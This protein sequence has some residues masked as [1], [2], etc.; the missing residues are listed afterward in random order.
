MILVACFTPLQVLIAKEVLRREAVNFSDVFFVYF[1]TVTNEKHQRYYSL[2][3][4]MVGKSLYINVPYSAKLLIIIKRKIA[5]YIYSTIYVASID[6][7][8]THYLLSFCDYEE[9][10]T[11]DDGVGNIIKSGTYFLKAQRTSLKK[12]LFTIVHT[13]LGRRYYLDEV[14]S[15]SLRH[16]TIYDKFDNCFNNPKYIALFEKGKT[17]NSTQKSVKNIILGTMFNEITSHD[18]HFI[19]QRLLDFMESLVPS[20][21]YIPHPRAKDICFKDYQIN[22]SD[23]AEDYVINL[24]N[25]GYEVNLYGFASSSQF[26]LLSSHN[27][28]IY[29]FD[30]EDFKPTMKDALNLLNEVLPS[31]HIIPL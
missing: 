26:N 28:N 4:D 3:A 1:S 18:D 5:S 25:E 12:R 6:D 16:Y 14:K 13:A 27:V 24:L 20:P 23:I 8:I 11:F 15:N 19:Q 21:L 30:S 9:L 29:V 22:T 2:L 7:S 17:T 10:V 31:G